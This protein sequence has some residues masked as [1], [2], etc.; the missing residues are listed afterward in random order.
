MGRPAK[1]PHEL[2]DA[3]LPPMRVTLAERVAAEQQ[4]Q[5][6]GLPLSDYGRRRIL[7]HRIQPKR[8]SYQS[9]VL[10]ELNRIGVNLNQIAR[11]ANAG[12]G[13][14]PDFAEVQAE[15]R[16]VLHRAVEGFEG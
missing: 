6:A 11:A 13:L 12:R 7:G 14:P 2:R 15:L 5:L 8:T 16:A 10:V 9:A 4:A 1:S 3:W